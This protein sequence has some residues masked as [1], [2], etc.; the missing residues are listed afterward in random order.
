MSQPQPIILYDIPCTTS[1]RTWSPN[2]MKTRYCLSY[3]GLA[4][5]TLW[6]EFPQIAPLLE[7]KG[8]KR[9]A[10]GTYTLPAIEDPSTGSII[11]DSLDIARYLDITY[12]HTPA[13]LPEGTLAMLDKVYG[14]F[15]SVAKSSMIF[16]VVGAEKLNPESKVYYHRTRGERYGKE[17][18]KLTSLEHRE[19][20]V[21]VGLE[22]AR[23]AWDDL[24]RLYGE[25]AGPFV[26]GESPC[27]VDFVV[28]SRIKFIDLVLGPM[29]VEEIHSLHGGRWGRLVEDLDKYFKY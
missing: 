6:V 2:T 8:L 7:S 26:L 18:E 29:E 14:A 19:R 16:A 27:F 9:P 13:L 25:N 5:T 20:L 24:D 17:W 4:F 15:A 10:S 11:A 1:G 23:E 28:A 12:P 22:S 21:R 3:K